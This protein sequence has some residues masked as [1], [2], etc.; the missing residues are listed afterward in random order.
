MWWLMDTHEEPDHW[1]RSE[2]AHSTGE[3]YSESLEMGRQALWG[4][5]ED[6]KDFMTVL[7]FGLGLEGCM[8]GKRLGD[9]EGKQQRQ[10]PRGVQ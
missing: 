10:R 9:Q 1:G 3:R 6:P 8:P 5:L 2:R 7:M 4:E